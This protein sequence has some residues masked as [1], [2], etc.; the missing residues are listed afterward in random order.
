MK[1]KSLVMGIGTLVAA[2]V[3]GCAVDMAG[4]PVAQ[5][6][7]AA[8]EACEFVV[9]SP[10][11]QDGTPLPEASTCEGAPFG[12]GV[13]PEL[14]WTKGPKGTKSYAIV[15]VDTTLRDAGQ[16]NFAYHWAAWNIPKNV[17]TLPG[18]IAGLDPAIPAPVAL[19]DSLKGAEHVQARGVERFFGP[20][21]SWAVTHAENCGLPPVD[22]ST[23]HYAFIVYALPE[24]DIEVPPYE[25]AV[26]ANYVDVLNAYFESFDLGSTE[27]HATANAVPTTTPPV[28]CPPVTP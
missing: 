7:H 28:P 20:C 13:S 18:G 6:E 24:K 19:P 26:N 12:T 4:E 27:I 8:T 16:P 21:P 5:R 14:N 10:D 17:R 11:F 3:V 23:D 1:E 25:P 9:T 15:F 2:S 22:R